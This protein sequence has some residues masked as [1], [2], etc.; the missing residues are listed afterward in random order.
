[1]K[2]DAMEVKLD[3]HEWADGEA[4]AACLDVEGSRSPVIGYL[5]R[6]GPAAWKFS[7]SQ[8]FDPARDDAVTFDGATA[9]D[10]APKLAERFRV[11][12]VP[13]D[14]LSNLRMYELTGELL[15]TLAVLAKHTDA[16]PGFISG[17]ASAVARSI[18]ADLRPDGEA[19]FLRA[20]NDEINTHVGRMRLATEAASALA[21]TF[22]ALMV[23]DDDDDSPSTSSPRH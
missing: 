17:L 19:A 15:T 7:S 16:R 11:I 23:K 18:V 2:A 4:Y 22:A 1:M 21:A 6:V 5:W 20:F 13:G 10:I 12:Q 14:R 8:T 9:D 3:P